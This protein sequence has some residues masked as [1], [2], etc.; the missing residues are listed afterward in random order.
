M[1]EFSRALPAHVEVLGRTIEGLALSWN[2]PYRVS[3][4]GGATFY[5][6]GWRPGSFARGIEAT[7]N[8]HELRIDHQ[9]VRVGRV[10][11]S[12]QE[13]GLVFTATADN[14]PAGD[15]AV[16]KAKDGR[17]RG[18]S[19]RYGSS[20][21]RHANGVIWR[22]AAVAR[23]LSLIETIRPQYDDARIE[24]VRG[25]IM[26]ARALDE[27]D[28]LEALEAKAAAWAELRERGRRNLA[29]DIRTL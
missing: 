14:T 17:Y 21:Q 20:D 22:T 1:K 13:A 16:E 15:R 27:P 19:I 23:E 9:D 26:L 4:D 7:G 24:S 28:E 3:D 11:F 18:V 6:E 2:R 12:E 5:A 10:S 29:R 8:T 25:T